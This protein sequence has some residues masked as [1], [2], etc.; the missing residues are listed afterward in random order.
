MIPYR[1]FK[2]RAQANQPDVGKPLFAANADRPPALNAKR[3]KS[4]AA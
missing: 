1:H 4:Q 2:R 3:E